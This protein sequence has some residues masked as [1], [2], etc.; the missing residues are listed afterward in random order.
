MYLGCGFC[1][2]CSSSYSVPDKK[3]TA[4]KTSPN[5]RWGIV[6]QV[7]GYWAILL[8]A[9]KSWGQPVSLWRISA[10]VAFGLGGIWLASSG[11]RHLGKQWQMKAAINDDHQLVTSGPYQIVRHPIYASMFAMNITTALLLGRL[12]WWP[13]GIVLCLAGIE[14]RIQVEDG[15]LRD[16]FGPRFEA[17]KRKVPAYLPL[18]R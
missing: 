18:I 14:I 5:F 9:R 12:P 6:L 7:L 8:P 1:G 16:R 15:L 3:S 13:I 4:I 10:A 2:C 17:W 11:V